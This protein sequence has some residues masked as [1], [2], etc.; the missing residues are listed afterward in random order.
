MKITISLQ[1]IN[2]INR[3][4][5]INYPNIIFNE[6]FTAAQFFIF[7]VFGLACLIEFFKC[8]VFE[9]NVHVR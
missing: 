1:V 3:K 5:Q 6:A 4:H 9:Y 2:L 7:T 8:L